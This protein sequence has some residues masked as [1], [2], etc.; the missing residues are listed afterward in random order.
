MHASIVK[1][2]ASYQIRN[3]AGAHAPGMPWKFSPPPRVSDPDMH[4][5][6]CVTH[7]LWCMPGSLTTVFLWIRRQGKTFPAFPV[8]AQPAILRIWQEAHA[9]RRTINCEVITR[10]YRPS[11]VRY[12]HVE[13]VCL[14]VIYGLIM[15]CKKQS[16]V[17][18]VITDCLCAHSRVILLCNYLGAIATIQIPCTKPTRHC[19][20]LIWTTPQ[21]TM[22][23]CFRNYA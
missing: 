21:P 23:H 3:I 15:S 9:Q 12:R 5:G 18:T 19:F 6:T 13:I 8:H 16:N 17:W 2:M 22:F 4:Q 10:T 11:E 14:V 20:K 1:S 7:V